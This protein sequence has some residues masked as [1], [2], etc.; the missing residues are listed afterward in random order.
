MNLELQ[1]LPARQGDAIWIRWGDGRQLFV[2]M[3]TEQTGNAIASRLAALPENKRRFD[4]LVVT[5]V[6]ADHIGGVLTC[7]ADRTDPIPGLGFGDV[8]FNGWDHLHGRK[9]PACST[10]LEEM[11]PAQGER[12]AGWLRDQ[13][14]NAAFDRGPVVRGLSHELDG[15]RLAVLGPT[16]TRLYALRDTWKAEVEI[17][18]AKGTL[19]EPLAGLEAFGSTTPPTLASQIDLELLAGGNSKDPSLTNATSIVL[20]LEWAGRRILLTGDAL[21]A[22]LVDAVETLGRGAPAAFDLVKVPHHGSR[23]NLSAD[24][25]AV[26]D[27]PTWLFSSDGSIFHHP[28]APAVARLLRYGKPPHTLAFNVS[29]RFNE[30]W[31]NPTWQ[32]LFQYDV[33]Y[34]DPR[35]G[36]TITFEPT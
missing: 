34:G 31:Q 2:D 3:G 7:V 4:L 19:T 20:L 32:G 16:Q 15:L 1:F 18:F 8:W 36:L 26:V 13:P 30:F 21:A 6:D 24:L 11:G 23:Q 27:C 22:D 28:D 12:L 25:A 14:W 9:T 29:S 10:T 35:D 33:Q 5:H 17:A